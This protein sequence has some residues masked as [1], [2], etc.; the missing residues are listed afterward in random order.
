MVIFGKL[1]TIRILYLL[2]RKISQ[3]QTL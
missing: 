3:G 2:I 1:P